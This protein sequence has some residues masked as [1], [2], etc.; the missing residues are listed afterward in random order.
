MK[1]KSL[2]WLSLLVASFSLFVHAQTFSVIHTFA[3]T[4][5]GASPGAGVTIKGGV[6]FGTTQQGGRG[7]G[8]VYQMTNTRS[9][10]S[11]SPIFFFP[12]DGSGGANPSARVVF[13]PDGH[14]YGT[15]ISGGA[16][17]SGV[18]FNLTPPLSICKTVY[19]AWKENVLWSFGNGNDGINPG[20]GDLIWDQWND[21]GDIWGTTV[22]GG[23]YGDGAIYELTRNGSTWSESLPFNFDFGN[24]EGCPAS[25]PWSGLTYVSGTFFGTTIYGYGNG[26]A[27]ELGG[28]FGLTC[29]AGFQQNSSQGGTPHAG[30]TADPAT[31][32]YG[33]A[34]DGGLNGGGTVFR[35]HHRMGSK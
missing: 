12:A 13:G 33:T 16:S 24:Y 22:N 23:L 4:G 32:L 2:L 11:F 27:W 7:Q 9:G 15:T 29:L 14:L 17:Q 6:L 18:V 26:I 8:G 21:E 31:N 30:L 28:P 1:Q 35:L 20:Y 3:G 34:S 5:D 19:C 10:W 25:V